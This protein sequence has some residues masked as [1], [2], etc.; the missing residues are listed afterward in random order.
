MSLLDKAS[1]ILTP[2]G[3]KEGKLYSVVPNSGVGDMT[4]TRATTA[5]RVNSDGLVEVVPY[6][7]LQYSQLFTN[8]IWTNSGSITTANQSGYDGTLNAMLLT[9]NASNG[10]L[11]QTSLPNSGTYAAS[12]YAKADSVNFIAIATDFGTRIGYFDLVNGITGTAT[13]LISSSITSVGNGWYRCSIVAIALSDIR[14]YPAS[15]NGSTVST[16]GSIFIQNSQ[17]VQGSTPKDYFPTT[18][19]LN[20][21]RIDYSNGGCPSILVEPQ[22]TNLIPNSV[23][24]GT[25]YDTIGSIVVTN[26]FANSPN[27]TITST[28]VNASAG[29]WRYRNANTTSLLPNTTYTF[30]VYV[31]SNTSENQTFRML[32][33][34]ATFSP[35]LVA[36]TQWQRFTFTSTSLPTVTQ[37]HGIGPGVM[38]NSADI[39]TWGWQIELAAYPTS[40]IPTTSATV[41]RNADSF[42]LSN[43]YTNNLISSVGGT[44]FVD[45][46]N[47]VAYTGGINQGQLLGLGNNFVGATANNIFLACTSGSR[48]RVWKQ[49]AGTMT[50]LYTTTTDTAK[51]AIKWNG[52]TAD[53]FVNGVKVVT[54]TAFTTTD[55]ESLRTV[56]VQHPYNINSMAL[57]PTPL[58]DTQCI[59][60]TSI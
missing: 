13:N 8:G 46:R 53:V 14:F 38:N 30:T 10:Y 44:W 34:N 49:I 47:N 1:L 31:K 40:Y 42:A 36:T 18:N 43:V 59:N 3:Y 41:T 9:K 15:I 23:G 54:S 35:D 6:N 22:R 17:L 20:V 52:T 7:L 16:T 24:G 50:S 32:L 33:Y 26:N 48:V 58:T 29:I 56:T 51:I 39:Q 11:R 60:L 45:L 28:R 21:P 25:G 19:R 2:N 5:T 12:V 57:F 27:N 37:I 4:V 55:L